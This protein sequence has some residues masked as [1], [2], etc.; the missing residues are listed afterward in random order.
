MYYLLLYSF[1]DNFESL[2]KPYREAHLKLVD[3]YFKSGFIVGAG[4]IGVDLD[5][6]MIVFKVNNEHVINKFLESD[7]YYKN[8]MV[9]DF[10]IK[11]WHVVKIGV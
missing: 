10:K 2:R 7:P 5:A 9:I 6:G 8:K 4:A 3:E 1:I 11:K